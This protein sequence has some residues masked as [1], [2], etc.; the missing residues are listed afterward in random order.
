MRARQPAVSFSDSPEP[1]NI[2]SSLDRGS[3]MNRICSL[4]IYL[5]ILAPSTQTTSHPQQPHTHYPH[6]L[7]QTQTHHPTKWKQLL[8]KLF[9][10]LQY[11]AKLGNAHTPLLNEPV[12]FYHTHWSHF[13]FFLQLSYSVELCFTFNRLCC[14]LVTV[15]GTV[16]CSFVGF[17]VASR[18]HWM[19]NWDIYSI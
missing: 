6:C 2:K 17:H 11:F 1:D 10:L 19:K 7:E 15:K 16:R 9:H 13:C 12:R 4:Y 3:Y 5:F 14:V 18:L 8:S